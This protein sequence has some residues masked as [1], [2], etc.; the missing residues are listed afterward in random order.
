MSTPKTKTRRERGRF[1]EDALA[2]HKR[3]WCVLPMRHGKKAPACSW[4]QY[5]STRPDEDTLGRLFDRDDL[6]GLGV[7]AG[8]I[9]GGL[10]CR[11]FDVQDSYDEWA[12]ANS[13]LA[14]TLPTV[15]TAR[16]A[17]VYFRG[18]AKG[19]VHVGDGELRGKGFCVLPPSQHPDGPTY[20]W[21]VHLPEGELLRIPN[22]VAVGLVPAPVHVTERTDAIDCGGDFGSLTI[23]QAIALT[24]PSGEG[25]RN[26]CVFD[27]ARAMKA[28][29][30]L[31]SEDLDKLRP[32]VREWHRQA[33]PRIRTKAFDETWFDFTN[34]W[35]RVLFPLGT[36]SMAVVVEKARAQSPPEAALVYEQEKLRLLVTLCQELQRIWGER[37]FFLSCR[38]AGDAVGVTHA[39]AQRW[40]RGLQTDDVLKLVKKG[41]QI[42]TRRKA[43]RYRYLPPIE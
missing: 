31:A 19:I 1:L 14:R 33:L 4:K 32:H 11:D 3:G 38:T 37:P 36:G 6:D 34:A 23:D 7:L 5:Q 27:L 43:S 2:Y 10:V 22:P 26:R 16:G 42:T 30:E 41:G 18:D 40:L 8:P 39:T 24:Q 21:I 25:E 35:K 9:S 15:K 17:H 29:P 20:A 13:D 12:R 28:V